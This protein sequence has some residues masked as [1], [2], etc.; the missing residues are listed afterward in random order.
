MTSSTQSR[1]CQDLSNPQESDF[2]NLKHL[3][4]HVNQTRDFIFIMEPQIPA[5]NSQGLIPVE[6]V[7]YS[8]S[9]WAGCQKSRRSTSDSL[10]TLFSVNIASTSRTQ[11]S[12]SRSSAC[13]QAL[14]LGIQSAILSRDV[15]II[16]K[17]DSNI[18]QD[19]GITTRHLKNVKAY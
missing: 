2:D 17:T 12:V 15:K 8:D 9:D 3:L 5:P 4:K 18:R 14:R 11:A 16:V 7:S 19:N 1:S 13:D 10:I 6:I